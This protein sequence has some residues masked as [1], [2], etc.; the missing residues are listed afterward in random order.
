MKKSPWA[1]FLGL[2]TT[3]VALILFSI[4]PRE[5]ELLTHEVHNANDRSP[6]SNSTPVLK[7]VADS[8]KV[9]DTKTS[10]IF[11]QSLSEL[12]NCYETEGSCGFPTTDPK[13]EHFA[14]GQAIKEKLIEIHHKA[15]EQKVVSEELSEIARE[16]IVLAD[17]HIKAEAL[18]LMATQP[19]SEANKQA[20][21]DSVIAYHDA[22][23]I[24]A[25]LLELSR[26]TQDTS[27]PSIDKAL[28]DALT[29]G[30]PS[31]AEQIAKNSSLIINDGNYQY[32]KTVLA[33]LELGSVAHIRLKNAL[34]EYQRIQKSA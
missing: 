33:K 14:I 22:A 6:Q 23:L 8:I 18:A 27:D 17:G 28:A 34:K 20:I 1:L 4:T 3:G 16:Y 19:T 2:F 9:K 32:F 11:P 29:K 15:L 26:Y 30:S 21:L 25:S 31:V 5:K 13:E 24:E 10:K 12:K 7:S